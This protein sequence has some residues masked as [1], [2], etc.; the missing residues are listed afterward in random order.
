M[1]YYIIYEIR[2]LI[3]NFI[4]IGAHTTENIND[5]YMGSGTN[6]SKDIKKIGRSN[7]TKTILHIF[8]NKG[9]MFNKEKEIV[10]ELFIQRSDTYNIILG[11][12]DFLTT[13]TVSVK[14]NMGNYFRVHKQ[15]PRYLSGELVG[16]TSGKVS[17]IDKNGNFIQIDSNDP[18]YIEGHFRGCSSGT[19][20]VKRIED[21]NILQIDVEEY[22]K[23]PHKYLSIHKD[24]V[25]VIDNSGNYFKVSNKDPQYLSKNLN[26]MWKGR[27]HS[28]ESKIKMRLNR[29]DS[30]GIHNSM[31]GKHHSEESKRKIREKLIGN[32]VK[33]MDFYVYDLNGNFISKENGINK[34]C[35]ANNLRKASVIA[36]LKGKS[37]QSGG[38]RFFYDFI[39]YTIV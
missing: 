23:F 38:K 6:I 32:S 31:F 25:T 33:K 37:Y 8:D 14:D 30:S 20:T 29:A 9:D 18:K 3:N 22:K 28:E 1:K 27:K 11:G 21:G 34:Y 16:C 24:K 12:G 10:N 5:G 4:Y 17:A 39:G 15:D 2:N 26:F 19:T 35:R 13:D 7:F 36:V